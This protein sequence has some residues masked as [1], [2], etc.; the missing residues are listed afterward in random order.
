DLISVETRGLLAAI[1]RLVLVARRGGLSDQ[2]DRL[3]VPPGTAV[4]PSLRDRAAP[5][6][7][8]SVSL[9]A[10][11]EFANGYGG[12]ADNGQEYVTLIDGDQRSPMPWINVISNPAFGFQVSTDGSGYTWSVNSREHQLTPWS[13]D[14]VSDP[15][16]EAFY[17]RDDVS[18]EFWSPTAL[19][20]RQKNATYQARHGFGYN[21]FEH[22]SHEIGLELLQ[23][24]P[25][26][27]P[28]KICRLKIRNLSARSRKLSVTAYVD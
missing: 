27:D 24:V 9:P 3:A 17:I 15:P 20:L 6:A 16:G 19:P 10:D 1:A 26:Q 22:I 14:P 13:N 4:T 25:L 23:F 5:P 7:S 11:L 21:R 28:V 8:A 12:F 18:G 2:L